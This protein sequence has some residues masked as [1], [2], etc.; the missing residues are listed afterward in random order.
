MKAS[1]FP[2]DIGTPLGSPVLPDVNKIYAVASSE[3]FLT[4]VVNS[5]DLKEDVLTT[6]ESL[7]IELMLESNINEG[8]QDL[9]YSDNSA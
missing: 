9:I 3:I 5:R 7:N 8:N 4:P 1:R 2:N 6:F